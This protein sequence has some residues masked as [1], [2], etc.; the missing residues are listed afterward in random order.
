MREVNIIL[1]ND[2]K[3]SSAF[4]GRPLNAIFL[5]ESFSTAHS[6]N[7]WRSLW[8]GE[9]LLHATKVPTIQRRYDSFENQASQMT[10]HNKSRLA[11]QKAT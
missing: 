7:I 2:E 10:F 9:Y 4:I 8:G 11:I 1:S 3:C 6:I 5:Q